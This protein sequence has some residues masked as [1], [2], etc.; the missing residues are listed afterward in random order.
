MKYRLK[1]AGAIWASYRKPRAGKRR[2]LMGP[3]RKGPKPLRGC[4][5]PRRS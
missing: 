4:Y 1:S 2:A 5:K 3:P